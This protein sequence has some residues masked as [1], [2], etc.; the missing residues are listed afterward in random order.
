MAFEIDAGEI[1]TVCTVLMG[2]VGF[3]MLFNV[4][5]PFNILRVVIFVVCAVGFILAAIFLPGMFALTKISF[6]PALILAV[7]A[8]MS[9]TMVGQMRYILDHISQWTKN[10]MKKIRKHEVFDNE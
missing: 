7:F 8:I 9:F 10:I 6:G 4:C 3:I 2:I 1:G 5:R